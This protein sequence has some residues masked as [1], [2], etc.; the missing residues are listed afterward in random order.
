MA[1][2]IN[3]LTRLWYPQIV[4]AQIFEQCK[5]QLHSY[6]F[7]INRSETKNARDLFPFNTLRSFSESSCSVYAIKTLFSACNIISFLALCFAYITIIWTSMVVFVHAESYIS[8]T[9]SI[10]NKKHFCAVFLSHYIRCWFNHFP[11]L[12]SMAIPTPYGM[13]F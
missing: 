4:P 9:S 11:V 5:N 13:L 10:Q 12:K 2:E 1:A 3:R 6:R 8:T 7:N